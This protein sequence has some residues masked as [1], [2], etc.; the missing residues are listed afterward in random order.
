MLPTPIIT[1]C[2]TRNEFNGIIPKNEDI[3]SKS[4]R[5]GIHTRTKTHPVKPRYVGQRQGLGATV[6]G[7]S[8]GSIMQ[9]PNIGE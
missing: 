8:H 9:K 4:P 7:R 2:R 5:T 1:S 6:L 3:T